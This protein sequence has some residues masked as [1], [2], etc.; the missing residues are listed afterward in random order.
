MNASLNPIPDTYRISG[1]CLK[2][3]PKMLSNQQLE[4]AHTG[5]SHAAGLIDSAGNLVVVREDIGRH[6]ALDKLIGQQLLAGALPLT[7]YGLMLSGRP[8]FELIQKAAMA[9]IEFIAGIGPPS[10]LAQE[11]AEECGITLAG[12]VRDT[13]YNLYTHPHRVVK[14]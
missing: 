12:F 13:G 4:F 8:G 9:G 14:Q 11:L 5:G 6:N 7:G 10:S 2:T 3:L 1:T